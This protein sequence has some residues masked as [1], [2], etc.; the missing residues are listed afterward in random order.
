MPVEEGGEGIGVEEAAGGR[1]GT[2]KYFPQ[3]GAGDGGQF[4]EMVTEG[5]VVVG[6][7]DEAGG[8]DTAFGIRPG[9][10]DDKAGEMDAV[11]L[12]EGQERVM[13][14]IFFDLLQEVGQFFFHTGFNGHDDR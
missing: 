12:R 10:A 9:G 7:E 14:G 5:L 11:Y 2:G 13:A 6:G 4:L 1:V 3:S 8:Y